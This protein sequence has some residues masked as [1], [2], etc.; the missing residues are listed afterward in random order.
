MEICLIWAQ[1]EKRAIGI[2]GELIW[3]SASDVH[4]FRE[5]TLGHPVVMGRGTWESLPSALPG[6]QN[7]VLSSR[8]LALKSAAHCESLSEALT[9]AS[10]L[11]PAKVFVIG[12]AMLHTKAMAI[13]DRLYVTQLGA[14]APE[15]DLFAP[16]IDARRF[17]LA[18]RIRQSIQNEMRL[19]FE[20][21]MR[22]RLPH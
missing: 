21:Y 17:A 3:H 18:K 15:S 8:K 11:K 10:V 5:L 12:G 4:Y 22:L 19:V 6:R 7:I 2:S 1:A 13:A 16:D 14:A 20:E 9:L